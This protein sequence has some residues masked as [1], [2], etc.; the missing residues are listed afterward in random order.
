MPQYVKAIISTVTLPF[1]YQE[2]GET[3]G[4]VEVIGASGNNTSVTRDA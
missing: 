1:L 3:E 4:R 2:K